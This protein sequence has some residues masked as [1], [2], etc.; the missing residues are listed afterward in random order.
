MSTKPKGEPIA[1][2][3]TAFDAIP[4]QFVPLNQI[5]IAPENLRADEGP[6]D[7]IPQLAE[8]LFVA[9]QIFP[10]LVRPGRGKQED[11][12]MVLDGRRRRFGFQDLAD[13]DRI[14]ADHPVRVKVLTTKDLQ[15]AAA[16]LPNTEPLT[17]DFV[18][19]IAAVGRLQKRRF[20][21]G[22]IAKALGRSRTEVQGWSLLAELDKSVLKGLRDGRISLRQAKLMT[23]LSAGDQRQLAD[24]ART[25]GALYDDTVRSRINGTMITIADRR[26]RLAGLANYKAAGGRVESDLF[27]ET[28]DI[29]LDQAVLQQVWDAQLQPVVEALQGE[30]LEVFVS[31]YRGQIPE[32]FSALPLAYNIEVPEDMADAV[33]DLD[34]KQVVAQAAVEAVA[35]IT[36]E[37]HPLVVAFVLA[38]LEYRRL[39]HPEPISAVTLIP[40]SRDGVEFSFH[41]LEVEEEE[42]APDDDE[43]AEAE[44]GD[45]AGERDTGVH[46]HGD[47]DIPKVELDSGVST[48]AL[49]ERYTDIATR[50]LLRALAD[51]PQAAL[52]LLV[53]RLFA[54]VGLHSSA[55]TN[56]S[57]STIDAQAYRRPGHQ[58]IPGLDAEV[59]ARLEA[60]RADYLASGQRPI[61][62]IGGLSHGERMTFLAELVAMTLNGREFATHAIRH[63]ARA[64]AVELAELTGYDIRAHWTPDL[65]FFSAHNKT[66]LLGMLEKM[67]A[68]VAPAASLKKADLAAYVAE[69]AV[70]HHWAPD[71][72]SW[73]SPVAVEASEDDPPDEDPPEASATAPSP[74]PVTAI[75]AAA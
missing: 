71:A 13:A 30:G 12:F 44:D 64:E 69:A 29:L 50:G 28:P 21:P 3:S 24:Y 62:W 63:G 38:A 16:F 27:G 34:T 43:R 6:D 39:L 5:G 18:D 48:H 37:T 33:A 11:P 23:K 46:R 35:E 9:G 49:N 42:A 40:H 19:V 72:L 32:G 56:L 65:D 2:P 8:T 60:R 22:E 36:A 75:A 68:E 55:D 10:L 45:G 51:D 25:Y 15:V 53:A 66:Q 7:D 47:V 26:V 54:N 61:A 52:T 70:E 41:T 67:G 14:P 58:P 1:A 74:A 73:K 20:S 31:Q 57:I 4:E 17:P 59:A